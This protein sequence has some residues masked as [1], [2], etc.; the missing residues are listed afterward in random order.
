MPAP[1]PEF[2][3]MMSKEFPVNYPAEYVDNTPYGGPAQAAKPG[4][5]KRG[6]V[7]LGIGATVIAGGGLIGYQTHA[8]N[9]VKAQEIALKAQALEI[10]KM[11]ELNRASEAN[12]KAQNKQANARQASIDSCVK[13]HDDQVGKVLGTTYRDVVE[14]CQTQYPDTVAGGDMEAAGASQTAT[15]NGAGGVNQGLLVGGGVL[16][17]ALVVAVKKG[18]RSN[19][20]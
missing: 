15:D 14:A 16:A 8:A 18:T 10:Q 11:R 5:T 4:L 19:P 2:D 1:D 6:K 17:V 7:A 12:K 13:S 20:A 3:R 9:E